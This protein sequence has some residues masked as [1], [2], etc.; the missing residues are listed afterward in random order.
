MEAAKDIQ[1]K[2]MKILH[3]YGQS[4][5]SILIN[6]LIAIIIIA[7]NNVDVWFLISKR[8]KAQMMLLH[9]GY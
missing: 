6:Y 4:L 7:M 2:K 8:D 9:C 5:C 3:G 1:R